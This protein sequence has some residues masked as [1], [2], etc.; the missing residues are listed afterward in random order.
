MTV[1][2]LHRHLLPA[3]LLAVCVSA[4]CNRTVSADATPSVDPGTVTVAERDFVRQLRVTGLTEATK[5]YVVTTPLLAG[6]QRGS[7]VVTKLAAAGSAVKVGDL[8]V[9][10]DSQT[11]DKAALDK[12]AEYEDLLQQIIQKR[13]EQDAARIKDEAE[14]TQARNSV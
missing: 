5:S 4:G 6:A 1:P 7:M 14:L 11:Q 8:L 2:C 3:V 13:A 9:Q 10:F 12:K